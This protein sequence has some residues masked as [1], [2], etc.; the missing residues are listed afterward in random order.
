MTSSS[1]YHLLQE[2][3]D[4][5]NTS[6]QN[7]MKRSRISSYLH[8]IILVL[9]YITVVFAGA[10]TT[11]I[12]EQTPSFARRNSQSHIYTPVEHLIQYTTIQQSNPL[13]TRNPFMVEPTS[14]LPTTTTDEK[15][16]M[17]YNESMHT[18]ISSS[19]AIR[20]STPTLAVPHHENQD[21]YL[22]NFT[23]WTR[24]DR[25]YGWIALRA[26]ELRILKIFIC[27]TASTGSDKHSSATPTPRPFHGP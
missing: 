17:L 22:I 3:N 10:P 26:I 21:L 8:I 4:E 13:H 12:L 6:S 11:V 7:H 27:T 18:Q 25:P 9:L 5:E 14:G 23:V 2:S 20:L 19:Q 15:W 24:F 1:T 16:E